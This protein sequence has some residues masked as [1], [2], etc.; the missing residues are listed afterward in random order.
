MS[1]NVIWKGA[2][3]I[4]SLLK[5]TYKTFC[6]ESKFLNIRW[7]SLFTSQSNINKGRQFCAKSHL[8]VGNVFLLMFHGIYTMAKSSKMSG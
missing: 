2:Q 7:R 5:V 3:N 8:H 6:E 1:W 4:Y